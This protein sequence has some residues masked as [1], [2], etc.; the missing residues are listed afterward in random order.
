MHLTIAAFVN[1]VSITVDPLQRRGVHRNSM[2]LFRICTGVLRSQDS[3][4]QFHKTGKFISKITNMETSIDAMVNDRGNSIG[5]TNL[6]APLYF[7]C[8]ERNAD[9][10]NN[11]QA[12]LYERMY[13]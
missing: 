6:K 10:Y 5:V 7:T 13:A 12:T 8:C 3:Y 1:K 11:A 9:R 4:Y 2:L